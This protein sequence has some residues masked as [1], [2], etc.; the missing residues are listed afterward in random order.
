M[1]DVLSLQRTALALA[2]V[3]RR[4][5]AAAAAHLAIARSDVPAA[6]PLGWPPPL[7]PRLVAWLEARHSACPP[8]IVRTGVDL[9]DAELGLGELSAAPTLPGGAAALCDVCERVLGAE[10]LE[11]ARRLASLELAE[12]VCDTATQATPHSA[13]WLD[14]ARQLLERVA[15]ARGHA[16][17]AVLARATAQLVYRARESGARDEAAVQAAVLNAPP[18]L[19]ALEVALDG[20][21]RASSHAAADEPAEAEWRR[22]LHAAFDASLDLAAFPLLAHAVWQLCMLAN[23]RADATAVR[24]L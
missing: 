24:A 10:V 21:A 4:R 8:A 13:D 20:R 1:A 5:S 7:A 12:R 14:A 2:L 23:H 3:R 11:D 18:L 16:A 9:I 6:S 15:S 22:W 17:I 19:A